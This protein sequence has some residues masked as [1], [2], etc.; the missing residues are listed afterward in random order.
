MAEPTS[1]YDAIASRFDRERPL[2]DGVAEAV[3]AAV[4]EAA[5]M[6][7]P[8][9]LD[10][11]AGTGRIGW[12]F[13]AAGDD[14]VGVDLSL[15]MLRAF[16]ARGGRAPALVQADAHRLPFGAVFDA[17]MLIQV[18]GGLSDWRQF[19]C[20]VRRVLRPDGVVVIGRTAAPDDGVDARMKRQLDAIL[21]DGKTKPRGR[22]VRG[23]VE[24]LLGASATAGERRI[25]GTWTARRSPR[26]F[27]ARHR[28]GARFSVLPESV[29]DDAM[30]RLAV[31]AEAT[32]GSLDAASIESHSFEL[33]LFRF[34]GV[35]A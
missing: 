1:A 20:E 2:P 19:A 24:G 28:G 35:A 4:L 31:W 27:L 15:G 26:Q 17:V 32:F 14:Y 9:V 11:G 6:P 10:V 16:T 21:G 8:R 12:P 25:A 34:Q 30:A 18:F 23:D 5:A 22:N 29:K 33:R 3:R 13:V 7:R